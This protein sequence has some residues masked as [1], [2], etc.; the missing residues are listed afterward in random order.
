MMKPTLWYSS[1]SNLQ[2]IPLLD[3]TDSQEIQFIDPF[4]H[5]RRGLSRVHSST[6]SRSIGDDTEDISYVS[7]P[8]DTPF[9][10]CITVS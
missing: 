2:E 1:I 4:S 10:P 9:I 3:R 5:D 6:K 7:S 8:I